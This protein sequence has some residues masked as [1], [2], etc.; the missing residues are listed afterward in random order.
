MGTHTEKRVRSSNVQLSLS[1]RRPVAALVM[2]V[3][4]LWLMPSM[5]AAQQKYIVQPIAE[6]KV[7]Q[8]P[9]GELFWRVESFPTLDEAKAAAPPYR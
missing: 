6:M 3:A 9:K 4:G 8:L 5:V 2:F 7:K 1:A